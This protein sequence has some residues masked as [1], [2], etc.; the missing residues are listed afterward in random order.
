[1]ITPDAVLTFWFSEHGQSD[2]FGGGPE[3]DALI[4]EKFGEAHAGIAK[5]EAWQWRQT[6]EGRLA[7]IIVLDQFSRQLFRN[8]PRAYAQDP[9]ALALAQEMVAQRLDR[10]L[11]EERRMFVYLPYMHSESLAIHDEALRLYTE[12]GNPDTLDCE[13]KHQ[14]AIARFGRYPFRNAPLGRQSTPEEEAYM[15]ENAGRGF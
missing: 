6:A 3:F 9:M 12:L 2:W 4:A 11:P 14:A 13:R 10:A 5:G 7:E 1:M 8:D 15:A